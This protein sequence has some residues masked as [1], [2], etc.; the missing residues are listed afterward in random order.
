MLSVPAKPKSWLSGTSCAAVE[1]MVGPAAHIPVELASSDED[2]APGSLE[3]AANARRVLAPLPGGGALLLFVTVTVSKYLS[4]E[5]K[6]DRKAMPPPVTLL[7]VAW[8]LFSNVVPLLSY[9][10]AVM[11]PPLAQISRT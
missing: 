5:L 6:F 11:P 4:S 2:P 1:G 9:S 8:T 10:W 3:S 7:S